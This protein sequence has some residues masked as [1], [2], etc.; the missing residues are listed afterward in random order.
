M[1]IEK[2]CALILLFEKYVNPSNCFPFLIVFFSISSIV[3][4]S[5]ARDTTILE[6]WIRKANIDGIVNTNERK[7]YISKSA[8]E[9]ERGV[10]SMVIELAVST[11][12][13]CIV[14]F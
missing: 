7:K 9:I 5:L 14:S 8:A 1:S 2:W 4:L 10:W 3:L 13:V 6:K 12:A 11:L